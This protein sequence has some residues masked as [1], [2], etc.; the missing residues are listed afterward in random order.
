MLVLADNA[1]REERRLAIESGFA[2][3]ALS[4]SGRLAGV[5]YSAEGFPPFSPTQQFN[6]PYVVNI[7]EQEPR[8]AVATRILL[9]PIT[10]AAD[11]LLILGGL[12]LVLLVVAL[13][14]GAM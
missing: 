1:S 12:A 14:H 7:R 11:G 9:T 3:P 8:S 4:L 6:R 2:E 13:P 10:V 5:R